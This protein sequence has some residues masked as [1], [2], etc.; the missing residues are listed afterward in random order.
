MLYAAAYQKTFS[1]RREEL[2]YQRALADQ[3]LWRALGQ[4][5]GVEAGSLQMARTPQGKPYFPGGSVH[6]SLSHCRGMVC[7]AVSRSPV[8]ADVEG[9]RPVPRHLVD[10]VC[11]QEERAWLFSQPDQDAAFLSLWTLKESVMK[12]SGQGIAYG[13]Q[14]ASFTF[15]EQ[16]PVFREQE[17]HLSQFTLPRGYMLSAASREERF[18]LVQVEDL[19]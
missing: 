9:P 15:G 2:A 4:E 13:F 5:Y 16:G 17:V 18:R 6:F 8:G 1:S 3:L 10:R 19:G 11:T 14:R 7:C 12:L